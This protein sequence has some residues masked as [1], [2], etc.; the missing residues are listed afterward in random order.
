MSIDKLAEQL[1]E[2]DI[3]LGGLALWIHGRE[4]PE[5]EDYWDGNF[6][7]VT[8][9]CRAEGARVWAQGPI[10]HLGE[11]AAWAVALKHIHQTLSGSADLN[12]MEPNLRVHVSVDGAG[13]LSVNVC[14]TPNHLEQK[15]EFDLRL[16]QSH[17]PSFLASCER[18]LDRFPVRNAERAR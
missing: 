14:I 10:L 1:G 4:F 9:C 7:M 17:L 12:C 18:V 16:D 11:L 5:S 3:Q 15:H 13:H 2:P 8:A 6:V